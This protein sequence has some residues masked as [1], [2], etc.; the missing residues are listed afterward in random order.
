MPYIPK[1][2]RS[3]A[4]VTPTSPGELNY[5]I[6]RLLDNYVRRHPDGMRY[7]VLNEAV[8]ALECAKLEFYRR[9]VADYEYGCIVK[10]GDVYT[11][12]PT[13]LHDSSS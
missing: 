3:G 11:C 1:D 6:T 10:N 7:H 12:Q 13:N 2:T 9:I 8:G 4:M 5:A